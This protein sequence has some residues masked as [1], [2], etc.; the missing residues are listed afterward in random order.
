MSR[1]AAASYGQVET[2]KWLLENGGNVALKDADGDTPLHYCE[3]AECADL[4][5]QHG[6]SLFVENDNGYPPYYFSV[7]EDREE[8]REWFE[9]QY[10]RTDT[11]LP[12]VPANPDGEEEMV[13]VNVEFINADEDPENITNL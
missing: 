4:L 6:A 13:E 1:H 10:R 12:E 11:I 2:L 9:N 7:W 3:D 8:M 5:L